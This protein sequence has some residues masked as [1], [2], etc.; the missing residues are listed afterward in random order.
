[1]VVVV[2]CRFRCGGG[3]VI[4][5]CLESYFYSKKFVFCFVRF[6]YYCDFL[7]FRIIRCIGWGGGGI[8]R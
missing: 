2:V 5:L 7:V 4:V 6:F 1:M 3:V 8:S